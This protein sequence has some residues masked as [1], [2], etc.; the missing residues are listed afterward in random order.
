MRVDRNV[1]MGSK[2]VWNVTNRADR[3]TVLKEP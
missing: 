1:G 3:R 2:E